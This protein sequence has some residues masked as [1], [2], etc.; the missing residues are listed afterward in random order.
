M[1]KAYSLNSKNFCTL[2]H[3]QT[4]T[5]E[6]LLTLFVEI[7]NILNSRPLT[8]VVFDFDKNEPLTP[9]HLLQIGTTPNLSPGVFSNDDAYSKRRWKQVQFLADQFWA[10]WSREYLQTLQ[11]RQK[12]TTKQSNLKIDDVV[13]VCDKTL[14]RGQWVMGRIIDTYP[15]QHNNV[16][17]ALVKT[18]NDGTETCRILSPSADNDE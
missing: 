10:R 9:N 1:G 13:L 8:P 12:W 7:E 3:Q 18:P 6:M 11:V 14:P 5:D 16:R 15:N 2:L 17:Q 4:V